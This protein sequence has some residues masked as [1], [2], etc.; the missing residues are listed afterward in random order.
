MPSEKILR[1]Y[2]P[3]LPLA[4]ATLWDKLP[5][6]TRARLRQLLTQMLQQAIP[7]PNQER[8]SHER[9]D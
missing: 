1:P 7:N 2:Q 8:S 3:R 5:E 9:Q 4:K 6:P